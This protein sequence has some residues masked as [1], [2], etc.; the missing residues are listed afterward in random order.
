MVNYLL[1]R[2]RELCSG[3]K[4]HYLIHLRLYACLSFSLFRPVSL[5][6]FLPPPLPFP[7]FVTAA[8]LHSGYGPMV[9]WLQTSMSLTVP[10]HMCHVITELPWLML[11]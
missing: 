7:F 11:S 1:E 10:T 6:L 5:L 2:H 4:I 9:G 3:K 8:V